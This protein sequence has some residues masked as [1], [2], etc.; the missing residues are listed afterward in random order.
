MNNT[1]INK[2]LL[3]AVIALSAVVLVGLGLGIGLLA[4]KGGNQDKKARQEIEVTQEEIVEPEIVEPEETIEVKEEPKVEEKTYGHYPSFYVK[5]NAYWVNCEDA[6]HS[7]RIYTDSKTEVVDSYTDTRWLEEEK[8]GKGGSEFH[9]KENK[10]KESR[11]GILTIKDNKGRT[12]N[13][14]VTQ[15]GKK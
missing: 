4:G 9:V 6:M 5:R 2:T 14:Y 8:I 12:I 11:K 15:G 1:Q 7:I 10:E 13:I 3:I